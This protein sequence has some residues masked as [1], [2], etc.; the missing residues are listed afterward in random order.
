MST[1][2]YDCAYIYVHFRYYTIY[3]H[4]LIVSEKT[5]IIFAVIEN[6]SGRCHSKQT[7]T[8]VVFEYK[9]GHTPCHQIV[10]VASWVTTLSTSNTSRSICGSQT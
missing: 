8:S 6:A 1:I 7:N 2:E 5:D 3:P 10:V 9:D 4:F